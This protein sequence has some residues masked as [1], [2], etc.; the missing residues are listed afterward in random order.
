[1]REAACR[2]RREERSGIF[3]F[4]DGG[5]GDGEGVRKGF[6]AEDI[7][8]SWGSILRFLWGSMVDLRIRRWK[9]EGCA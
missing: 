2:R 9:V 3:R 5:G 6:P 8:G 1:V 7:G 4:R